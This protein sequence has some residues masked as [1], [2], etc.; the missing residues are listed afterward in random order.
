MV[1]VV[2]DVGSASISQR[3]TAAEAPG[4]GHAPCAL[5][6]RPRDW[7]GSQRLPLVSAGI[8]VARWG[9]ASGDRYAVRVRRLDCAAGGE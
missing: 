5:S 2:T 7:I 4:T 1:R 3:R 6:S 9:Q 8:T